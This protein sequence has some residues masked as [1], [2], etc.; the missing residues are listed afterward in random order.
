[1]HVITATTTSAARQ[2][3]G[4]NFLIAGGLVGISTITLLILDERL[5]HWFVIPVSVCGALIGIDAVAW[6]RRQL[7]IFDP[8]ALLALVG[9]HFFYIAPLLHVVLDHWAS[10]VIPPASW[11][12]AL[13]AMASLNAIGLGIY[14]CVVRLPMRNSAAGRFRLDESRFYRVMTLAIAVALI[15]FVVELAMFGGVGGFLITMTQERETLVGMG[16]LLMIAEQ[17]PALIFVYI[18]VR[19]RRQL[20]ARRTLVFVI[21]CGLAIAQF[22]V[23]GL[24]GSRSTTVWPVLLALMLVHLLLFR[25]SRKAIVVAALILGLFMYSY[26]LYKSAGVEVVDIARGGRTIAEVSGKTG[27]DVPTVVLHDLARADVQALLLDR[28]LHGQGD[29]GHG[30][31]YLG[32]LSFLIP[33]RLLPGSPPSKV[34]LGTET[35]YGSGSYDAGRHASRVYGIAGEA[36]LNFGPLGVIPSFVVLALL[37]RRVHHF[38]LRSQRGDHL[39]PKILAP[40]LCMVAVLALTSD[41]DNLTLI[42]V[43]RFVPLAVVVL[44]A[45]HVVRSPKD[46]LHIQRAA[47]I[48]R[49]AR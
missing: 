44:L 30:L 36:M 20:A 3:T 21:V 7:D 12:D 24:R 28:K 47:V 14:R 23:G 4:T 32:D 6:L 35:L 1:M 42:L 22:M 16:W 49:T 26:G 9:L 48:S 8:Q 27:R 19:W 40:S 31:S 33:D 41:L 18:V 25:L 17:S 37:I 5:W 10:H 29:L 34:V 13:G 46:G 43:T 11:R 15:A 2:T 45:S 38:Y 39:G